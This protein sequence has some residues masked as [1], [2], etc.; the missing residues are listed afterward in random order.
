MVSIREAALIPAPIEDVLPI[1]LDPAALAAC[2]PAAVLTPEGDGRRWQGVVS[3]QLQDG[4][5]EFRC[6]FL[7]QSE[8]SESSIVQVRGVHEGSAITLSATANVVAKATAM[9]VTMPAGDAAQDPDAMSTEQVVPATHIE[10][11]GQF[12]MSGAIDGLQASAQISKVLF[13]QFVANVNNRVA[14]K[15]AFEAED[16]EE[17]PLTPR[18]QARAA[19]AEFLPDGPM[20]THRSR[21]S[22]DQPNPVDLLIQIIM[23]FLAKLF[24]S[25]K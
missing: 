1:I 25:K 14:H 23:D 6:E 9:A 18:E 15:D 4:L 24:P 20:E 16:G 7:I 10:A 8:D 13:D 5:A 12:V 17:A 19:A 22:S 21:A 11:G 2:L 3:L